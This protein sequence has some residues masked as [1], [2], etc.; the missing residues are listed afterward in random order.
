MS[1][2]VRSIG[3]YRLVASLGSGGMAHVHLAVSARAGG[4]QKLLVL[5][6][7]REEYAEDPEFRRM[8]LD[9]ARIA[10]RLNHPNVVHT[11]EVGEHDGKIFIAME[12]L[13]GQAFSSVL[14]RIG[15]DEM[16]LGVGLRV[17]A[18]ALAGLHYAH[19][20]AD[21]D[22][23]PFGLVHRDVSPQNVFVTYMGHAKLLDFGIAKGT[24]TAGQTRS[25]VIK[26]K[27]GYMAP[28]QVMGDPLDRRADVFAVGVMLWELL[29]KTRFVG[30]TEED[31]AVITRRIQGRER[32]IREAAPGA[33]AELLEICELAMAHD[34]ADRFPS[35]AAM[36]ERLEA[37]LA[38]EGGGDPRAVASL[39]ETHFK[40]ERS[41]VRRVVEEGV[42]SLDVGGPLATLKTG[43]SSLS[44][45]SSGSRSDVG[46]DSGSARRG[47]SSSGPGA[48]SK[49][50]E[51]PMLAT[52]IA[53]A[54]SRSSTPL[55]IGAAAFALV[56]A[57]GA[58]VLFG[59]RS[60][61]PPPT[62][63][64]AASVSAVVPP[65][66]SALASSLPPSNPSA[67]A[68]GAVS[69]RVVVST[70]PK[71]AILL[72][73]GAPVSNPYEG[74]LA[75]GPH[76]LRAQAAGFRA[77]ERTLTPKD[78]GDIVLTL[79]AAPR[80]EEPAPANTSRPKKPKHA[81]D[82]TDPYK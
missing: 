58:Y 66:A 23:Q 53:P 67:P 43:S 44:S 13:E 33:P 59:A 80:G 39:L 60:T 24:M 18:D 50:A 29:A 78:T 1:S 57:L 63:P 20:L 31:V 76:K 37:Y 6:S 42:K 65:P 40:E 62:S 27:V 41:K 38:R 16:P 11:Y 56:T 26:G 52:S 74:T 54:S 64:V 4:F 69:S 45:S 2:D 51:V 17:L 35:A 9:E 55:V 34:A 19:D 3:D 46:A 5:K 61:P 7:L 30:K 8:F 10:A 47:S 49:S 14:T 36:Q 12:Y 77:T 75:D 68:G 25:G 48:D 32:G 72:L 79:E 28:E 22:G 70:V 73:D 71:G 15:R 82:D 21:F 81:I